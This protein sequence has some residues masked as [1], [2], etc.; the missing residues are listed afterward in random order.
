MKKLMSLFVAAAMWAGAAGAAP[1]QWAGNNHWYV[2][3]SAPKITW[4]A[5]EAAAEAAGGYLA[6]LTSQAESDFVYGAL[7][8]GTQP[9]WLGGIQ[10]TTATSAADGWQWVTGEAWAFTN[11]APGEPNN[12]GG[13]RSLAFAYFSP[14]KW[15]NAPTNYT[16][17]GSGGYIVEYVPEPASLALVGIAL[18]GL[19]LVR[20]KRGN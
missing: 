13:E 9:L 2:A 1:V 19:G 3:V 8:V 12:F 5:A 4:T 20:R 10:A 11:W 16:G 18:G 14:S 15:N 6:T 17:Y 7:G